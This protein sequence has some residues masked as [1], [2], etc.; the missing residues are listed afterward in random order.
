MNNLGGDKLVKSNFERLLEIIT[1]QAFAAFIQPMEDEFFSEFVPEFRRRIKYATGFSGSAGFL[2]ASPLGSALFTDGRY[3]EQARQE[4]LDGIKIY[5]YTEKNITP[6]NFLQ[7]LV[8]KNGNITPFKIGFDASCFPH[9]KILDLMAV[10]GADF[11]ACNNLI[12]KIWHNKPQKPSNDI[13]HYPAIFAGHSRKQKLE[14]LQ[15]ILQQFTQHN[16]SDNKIAGGDKQGKQASEQIAGGGINKSNKINKNN[17]TTKQIDYFIITNPENTC[18]ISNLRGSDIPTTAVFLNY[19]IFDIK[20]KHLH[21]FTDSD[22]SKMPKTAEAI[23]SEDNQDNRD[24][25]DNEDNKGNKG[26]SEGSKGS[27]NA[28]DA[29]VSF[30][31]LDDFFTFLHRLCDSKQ[32]A[33]IAI[34]LCNYN[35]YQKLKKWAVNIIFTPNFI[36]NMQAVKT[37]QEQE[38]AKQI[39]I[40]DALAI[41]K[42][43]CWLEARLQHSQTSLNKTGNADG[44]GSKDEIDLTSEAN[45][46]LTALTEGKICQELLQ[47]RLRNDFEP[48]HKLCEPQEPHQPP[49]GQ[50]LGGGLGKF[51]GQSFATIAGFAENSA[52]IHYNPPETGGSKIE[53]SKNTLLLIDSGGQYLGGTTDIT[54]TIFISDGNNMPTKQMMQDYTSVLKGHIAIARAIFPKGT[55]GAS[56]DILARIALW[57]RGLNFPH[58]TGHGV[59]N[60]LNVHESGGA[61]ISGIRMGVN[62]QEPLKEGMIISNE[63]GIYRTGQYGIRIE[64]LILVKQATH[65]DFLEFETISLVPLESR[66]IDATMISAEERMWV[67]NYH[68]KIGEKLLPHI[69][70]D[71]LKNYLLAKIKPI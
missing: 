59:G 22:F 61:S 17:K 48:S 71:V 37:E 65:E 21:I 26:G 63:P 49:S 32:N 6:K 15:V 66:L 56:L 53:T 68:H 2:V 16:R 27:K 50:C 47:A 54:R 10:R 31:K 18:Y 46:T 13:F 58:G 69:N 35:I 1:K 39:H 23:A 70:D 33:N 34:N 38:N 4:V 40:K 55:F 19:G 44:V 28:E 52:I 24:N 25:R 8:Q 20:Q 11:I 42:F 29:D 43:F 12:D 67:N 14:N 9:M 57:Q 62:L 36:E 7:E 30:H 51:I 60:C 41:C 64:N 45:S 3:T 5:N